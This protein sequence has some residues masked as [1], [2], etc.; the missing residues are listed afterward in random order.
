[1]PLSPPRLPHF[2]Q[3]ICWSH[4]PQCHGI[5][6]WGLW[7]ITGFRGWGPHDGI[8]CS[9][10]ETAQSW[11]ALSLPREDTERKESLAGPDHAGT[12]IS[13]IQ[14]PGLWE[15]TLLLFKP[16]VF[17][18]FFTGSLNWLL[19]KAE[20][21]KDTHCPFKALLEM[22]PQFCALWPVLHA[23]SKG[24]LHPKKKKEST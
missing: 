4:K 17:G 3:I 5:W 13:D 2:Q 1:M 23:R 18:V 11:L 8:M 9:E 24:L 6:R 20:G 12:L 15:K 10:E 19:Q 22:P 16:P 7:E 21:E 14:S